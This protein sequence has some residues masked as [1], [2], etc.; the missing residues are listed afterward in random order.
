MRKLIGSLIFGLTTPWMVA[1]PASAADLTLTN[2]AVGFNT[3]I[4]IDFHEPTGRLIMSVNYPTGLPNNL[5]LVTPGTGIRNQFSSLVGLTNELKI[6]TV[7]AGACQGGFTVGEVF[8]GNGN[9]GQVIRISADGT[10]VLNPWVT[11]GTTDL[12]RGSLFQDRFCAAGGDLIVVTGNEQSDP[13][14][15]TSVGNVYRVTSAGAATLVGTTNTHLEGV[16]TVPNLPLVYGPLAG[17][18]LAGAE[19]LISS[20][21][22]TTVSYGVNGRIYAFAPNALNSF[23]TIGGGTGP[24]CNASGQPNGCN[25]ATTPIHPEDLDII[26]R[27]ADFFGINFQNFPGGRMLTAPAANFDGRCGQIFMT[28]EFPF[29]GT[30]GLYALHW[31]AATSSVKVDLLTS[32]LDGTVDAVQQWEHTTFTSG[33]DCATTITIAKTPDNGTFSIGGTIEWTI[34]VTNT[35]PVTAL[36]VTVDDQLPTTAGLAWTV[37]STSQGSC[38]ISAGQALHCAL[39][40]L[41][42]GGGFATVVVR[43]TSVATTA[44][45]QRLDNTATAVATNAGQVSN[46]GDQTCIPPGSFTVTK[47][48]KNATYN[49]GD[50]I[51]FSMV[52]TSTG[53]GTA[54]NVVL[55]DPLPTLGNLNTWTISADASGLCTIVANTL[56]CPF[57]NLANGQVRSVTVATNAAGGAN[58]TACTGVKLNNTVTVTATGLPTKTDTGDYTCT[59]P[60]GLI[61][62]TQTTCQDV[63]DGTAATLG[64]INYPVSGGKIGQGINPGVFFY[65]TKITTTVPNQVVTV[66]ETQNDAAALFQTHSDGRLYTLAC[67]S[68]TSGTDINGDTGVSYTIATPG[69]YIIS[70]KYDTKTIAGTNAPTS[71]P[72]TYTFTTSLGGNT[73]ASVLLKKK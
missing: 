35:G 9:A 73:S 37:F 19:D 49:I 33:Q 23:F 24:A 39:G 46:P 18:I 48:P 57:G 20:A 40:D 62:P 60:G 10:S 45:C 32:N 13:P 42:A 41:A 29:A 47:N 51:S 5:D 16:T 27:N 68:F 31:D 17:R 6:A 11:L 63:R 25:F 1:A 65:Y 71:D 3:P 50:N 8:T 58:A 59:P 67:S 22:G 14:V 70:V 44:Q 66:T 30:S 53:P 55:N 38:S 69:T 7:R 28:Q 34:V 4:G 64:Q 21:D 52:V 43:S 56:N 2:S 26:R 61:A 15:N 54:N 12:V 36:G 72:V